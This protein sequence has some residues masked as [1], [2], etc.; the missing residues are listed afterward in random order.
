LYFLNA[1]SVARTRFDADDF[2]SIDE[3]TL[4]V[5]TNRGGEDDAGIE[6]GASGAVTA[7]DETSVGVGVL[8]GVGGVG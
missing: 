6:D 1:A 4:G 2:G 3:P 7:G 8:G 5:D